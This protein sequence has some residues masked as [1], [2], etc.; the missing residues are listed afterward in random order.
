MPQLKNKIA[1]VTGGSTGIG[2]AINLRLLVKRNTACFK[3]ANWEL[4]AFLEMT[5]YSAKLHVVRSEKRNGA[6]H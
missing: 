3:R 1:V 4:E 6:H 2:L 5:G